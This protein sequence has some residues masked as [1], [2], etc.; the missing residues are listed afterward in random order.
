MNELEVG[1]LKYTRSVLNSP[2][3]QGNRDKN[4]GGEDSRQKS[5]GIL[6]GG[7]GREMEVNKR[8]ISC[9]GASVL[10]ASPGGCQPNLL[11]TQKRK[12]LWAC[13]KERREVQ[14]RGLSSQPC[15]DS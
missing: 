9:N 11:E 7:R 14:Q 2:D 13:C 6:P 1:E 8:P 3:S 12:G 4:N 15:P 5:G 10:P